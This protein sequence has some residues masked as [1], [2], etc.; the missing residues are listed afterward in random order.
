MLKRYIYLALI[1]GVLS[2]NKDKVET[3]PSIKIKRV[4]SLEVRQGQQLQIYLEYTDKEGDLS[5][6]DLTY[7][8]D[9]TNINPIPDE[10]SNG[11]I[12]TVNYKLPEFPKT[13][14]G[15]IVV[16]IPYDGLMNE[17]PNDNDTMIFKIFVRDVAGNQSDT[18]TTEKI[19]AVQ[20]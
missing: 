19:V 3:K 5:N 14:V 7:I 20:L 13:T 1:L 2:C 9:R 4:S 15:E 11:T 18:V 17:D 8:R 10:Q 16:S 12:D 6:G